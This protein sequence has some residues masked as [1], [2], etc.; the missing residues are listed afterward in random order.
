MSGRC[1][2]EPDPLCFDGREWDLAIT[3]VVTQT[4]IV[5]KKGFRPVLS[6]SQITEMIERVLSVISASFSTIFGV[7]P[8]MRYSD[9]FEQI[10]DFATRLAK[11]HI[12]PDGNKRT[13]VMV[14]LAL[15]RMSGVTLDIEDPAT[16]EENEVYLWIQDIVTERRSTNELADLLRMRSAPDPVSISL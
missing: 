11:D 14:S 10:A 3:V 8:S 7:S 6:D 13:T 12:F 2:E 16:P 15:L 9:A 4:K 5:G 1:L